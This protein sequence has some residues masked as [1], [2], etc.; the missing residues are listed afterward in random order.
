MAP[1]RAPAVER[2]AAAALALACAAVLGVALWL[3][4]DPSGS[5][6]H[7]QLNLPPCGF[8]VAM[9]MPCPSCGMTTAFSHAA[10]GNLV[11]SFLTQPLGAL[12]ALLTAATL[13]VC[14]Y[15]ACTGSM[16]GHALTS[17]MTPRWLLVLGLCGGAAWIYKI[18]L[19]RG[20]LPF[21]SS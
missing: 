6:T 16:V 11:Q 14:A 21:I 5:G 2:W 10:H 18:L 4:P 7:R 3:S 8:M 1:L 17:R 15:V 13:V 20:F 12:L 9:N 19:H